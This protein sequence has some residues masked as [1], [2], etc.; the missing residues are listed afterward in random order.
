MESLISLTIS[1]I[2]LR[3]FQDVLKVGEEVEVLVKSAENG[4]LVLSMAKPA[5]VPSVPWP[6]PQ[7]NGWFSTYRF[8][9][10]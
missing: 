3:R 10:R 5:L 7:G 2:F 9:I 8:A 1:L 6:C 4:R